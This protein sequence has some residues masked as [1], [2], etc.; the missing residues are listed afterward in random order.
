MLAGAVGGYAALHIGTT[1][2]GAHIGKHIMRHRGC[3][4]RVLQLLHQG[5]L[6]QPRIG[7]HQRMAHIQLGTQLR[8]LF[9][10]PGAKA[11]GGG[12]VPVSGEVHDGGFL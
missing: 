1:R 9:E 5:Q 12:V 6:G 3:L 10:P 7:N 4:K 11:D 2:I 8:Q